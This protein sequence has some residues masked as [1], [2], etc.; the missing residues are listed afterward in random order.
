[1]NSISQRPGPSV[2]A[3]VSQH[4]SVGFRGGATPR[5]ALLVLCW[6][7][8]TAQVRGYQQFELL[9]LTLGSWWAY[10]D[11]SSALVSQ[12]TDSYGTAYITVTNKNLVPGVAG[13]DVGERAHGSRVETALRNDAIREGLA[14]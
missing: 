2:S 3:L 12:F 4:H 10:D 1:M 8:W 13:H 5:L 14:G 11:G 6:C 9:P 7:G